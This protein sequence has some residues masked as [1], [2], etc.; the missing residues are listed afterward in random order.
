MIRVKV[1]YG[2]P[3]EEEA[4]V[5]IAHMAAVEMGAVIDGAISIERCLTEVS[6]MMHFLMY[7]E[8]KRRLLADGIECVDDTIVLETMTEVING[9]RSKTMTTGWM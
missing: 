5:R 2:L 4:A 1:E 3:E 6:G 9:L 7:I 8:V